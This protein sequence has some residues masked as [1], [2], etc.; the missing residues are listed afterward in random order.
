[1]VGE[2]KNG[3]FAQSSRVYNDNVFLVYNVGSS[4]I[5]PGTPIEIR[6]YA[7]PDGASNLTYEEA[8]NAVL[9]KTVV[10]RGASAEH[11]LAEK[12][13]T[14]Y[15]FS[16]E[17]IAPGEI[18]QATTAGKV[19]PA[20]LWVL[21]YD[22]ENEYYDV[23]TPDPSEK[24]WAREY[25]GEFIAVPDADDLKGNT[26]TDIYPPFVVLAHSEQNEDGYAY[27]LVCFGALAGNNSIYF[28]KGAG[29]FGLT[30]IVSAPIRVPQIRAGDYLGAADGG[31]CQFSDAGSGKVGVVYWRG[32]EVN[33]LSDIQK[34]SF[35]T[36]NE[37][38]IV[39]AGASHTAVISSPR[40]ILVDNKP[41]ETATPFDKLIKTPH[42]GI[43]AYLAAGDGGS[44]AHSS[45]GDGK[46]ALLYWRGCD[47]NR[48][49]EIQQFIFDN[50][51]QVLQQGHTVTIKLTRVTGP[52]GP[53]GPQGPRG[54]TGPTG[55]GLQGPRGVTGPR[56][57]RGP[58]GPA[59]SGTGGG[60]PGPRGPTG[61]TGIGL[62]GPTGKTGVG[63]QGPRGVTGPTG[64]QGLRGPT[65]VGTPGPRGATGSVGPTGPRGATGPQGVTGVGLPGERGPAGQRGLPGPAGPQGLRGPTGPTGG[66]G[67]VRIAMVT[68]EPPTGVESVPVVARVFCSGGQLH[69]ETGYV[70]LVNDVQGP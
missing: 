21:K 68:G 13:Q 3:A 59:G 30:Q 39:T 1:M 43:G 46:V 69:V 32:G 9:Q 34:L 35:A 57:L 66:V 42:L 63:A 28:D 23:Y 37:E 20:S 4:A 14:G 60:I 19:F 11:S 26:A 29:G 44:C 38:L 12:R 17:R 47:V 50:S 18:G 53:T 22:A 8:Q 36:G 2:W 51:F 67:D 55:V 24:L 48:Y 7:K 5:E 10:L 58:T 31:D 54:V 65:G 25:D 49:N 15:A 6:G 33:G 70:Y 52:T 56:G 62:R 45:A 27:C 61:P 64:P 40:Y 41:D 16:S